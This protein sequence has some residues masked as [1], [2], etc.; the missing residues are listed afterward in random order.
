MN[1]PI[2]SL[3]LAPPHWQSADLQSLPW[4][5][6]P[7]L[8][9]FQVWDGSAPARWKTQVQVCANSHTLF[10]HFACEDADIWGTYT[11]RDDPIYDE[12]VVEFFIGA[13]ENTP[14]DYFEFEISPNGV[15]FD[16]RVHNPL[17]ADGHRAPDM[18][19]DVDWN[20]AGVHWF[21]SRIETHTIEAESAGWHAALAIPWRSLLT[22]DHA[23][24]SP[25]WRANFYRIERP[26]RGEPEFSA[27]VPPLGQHPDFHRAGQ[28]G[29]LLWSQPPS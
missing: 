24:P 20:C 27:W 7:A 8:T 16:A 29:T 10:I 19:V 11:Q 28:F 3:P 22:P 5:V 18:T 4:G 26:H 13:G 2:L 12:E 1:E 25:V 23:K 9:P 21:A 14:V 15:L 6:V 17:A